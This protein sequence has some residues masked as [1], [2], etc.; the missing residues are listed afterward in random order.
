VTTPSQPE[1]D[2][3]LLE[4]INNVNGFDPA[5]LDANR[6]LGLSPA[7]RA[8]VQVGERRLLGLLIVC[9]A[10]VLSGLLIRSAL[11][12]G[13]TLLGLIAGCPLGY[14]YWRLRRAPYQVGAAK[15]FLTRDLP[16]LRAYY[17]TAG[18]TLLNLELAAPGSAGSDQDRP[19]FFKID[20]L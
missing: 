5:S 19:A 6:K 14:V 8:D 2:A 12:Y 15:G 20:K 9:A 17:L 4:W 13:L 11:T 7:Q 18:R 3:Q 1:T 10:A 16:Y